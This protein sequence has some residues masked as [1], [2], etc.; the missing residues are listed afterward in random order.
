MGIRKNP[1]T[2][3]S[4]I[5]KICICK[6]IFKGNDGATR[7]KNSFQRGGGLAGNPARDKC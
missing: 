5:V 1:L 3:A 2:K 7:I 4:F 6:F